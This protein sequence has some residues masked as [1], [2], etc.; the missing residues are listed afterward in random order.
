MIKFLAVA[1]L[2]L[3]ALGQ[4]AYSGH[5]A[6]TAA[7]FGSTAPVVPLTYAARTDNCVTGTESGCLPST[8]T[9]EA[10][11]ALS[12]LLRNSD[13]VP[14]PDITS[15]NA[16]MNSTGTDPDFNS[17][18]VMATDESTATNCLG[19]SSWP[20][21]NMGSAGEYDAFS[22]DSS[23]MIVR[24]NGGNACILFLNPISIHGKTCATVPCVSLTKGTVATSPIGSV[25][26]LNTY[27]LVVNGS[28]N[29]SRIP[30]ESN[31]LY[32]LQNPP[33]KVERV[34]ICA[35]GTSSPNCSAWVGPGPLLRTVY[36]DFS[37]ETGSA[38][39]SLRYVSAGW[40]SEFVVANDGSV[41]YGLG[42][43]Q[44]WLASWTPT[45]NETFLYPQTNAPAGSKGYQ[46]TAVSGATGG[47]QP[48]W[49]TSCP[50]T[51]D[52]CTDGGVTWLNIG[53]IGGQGPGFDVVGYS[54]SQGSWRL[55]TRIARIYRGTGNSAPA[56]PTTTND[57][58]ACTR[59]ANGGTITH[60]CALPDEYTLHDLSQAQNG[61]YVIISPTGGE[62][63]NSPGNWN[64]G[65][66]SGQTS[67]AIWSYGVGGGNGVWSAGITYAAH[68][69]VVY[70]N[71][72]FYYTANTGIASG[73]AA[74]PSNANWTR[75]EAYPLDYFFDIT[76]T[77]LSPCTDYLHCN[78][79]QAQ[80]FTE[81]AYGGHFNTALYSNP[82]INGSLNPGT[83]MLPSTVPCDFHGSWRQG[84]TQDLA[85]IGIINTCVPAWPT[86]YT[87]AGYGEIEAV[88]SDGSGLAYRFAHDDNTGSS[89]FF[90]DQNNVGVISYLGDLI[91]W[92]SDMM[93][94]RGDQNSSN[95]VCINKAR[96]MYKP[97]AGMTLTINS[98][99]GDTVLP[100][101][102]NAGN[103]IYQA[104]IA[105]T[106]SGT[107]PTGGWGQISP[108]TI[109]QVAATST[110][111]TYT[112][113]TSGSS[114][115]AGGAIIVSGLTN[116]QF[117]GSGSPAGTG[118][119]IATASSS[120]FTITGS[121]SPIGTTTDSGTGYSTQAWG[122]ATV[123]NIG[124]N[125]CRSD[126]V[127]VDALSAHAAP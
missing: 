102:G 50:N 29:F 37:S 70:G 96:A 44:D 113:T 81:K 53:N 28:W 124:S 10:G 99:V 58:V 120:Q 115:V 19:S 98:G 42:G 4:A 48:N 40:S 79:H 12:F 73:Q 76:T 88:K 90:S 82:V 16:N 7:T 106:T 3:P 43:G 35:N 87:A 107:A 78:G 77:N 31:V 110:T 27:H 83:V 59:A 116:T 126:I 45:V 122:A 119:T 123:Q 93:G 68:D 41:A 52:T 80:G 15:G 127:I 34:V 20:S 2:C 118:M 91:A 64:W 6:Y 24:N 95:A 101:T 69:V 104:T 57:D 46:A 14:F 62:G 100:V 25:S 92:G 65:T 32:E 108:V 97:S 125:S 21:W 49:A 112:Y 71:P 33:T 109:T 61:R 5:A 105:G 17:Y 75:T 36:Q 60:P 30:G 86:A 38:A 72:A 67:N 18:L 9:G 63:A 74:P 117:N 26:P 39:L 47:T 89:A 84:G 66:L 11:S 54:P 13:A 1:A 111:A 121:Y 103:Y 55:N 114:L 94:K 8:T 85:P 51:G 56:G 23:L 22:T